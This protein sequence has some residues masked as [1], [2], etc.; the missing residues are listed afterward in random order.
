MKL[1]LKILATLLSPLFLY[2]SLDASTRLFMDDTPTISAHGGANSRVAVV[3][4]GG[5]GASPGKQFSELV[6]KLKERGHT[7]ILE[8]APREFSARKMIELTLATATPDKYD[9]ILF[10]GASKGGLLS[11]DTAREMRKRGDM[12]PV[13]IVMID[14]PLYGPDVI[15]VPFFLRWASIIPLGA[16]SNT[17]FHPPFQD[18]DISQMSPAVNQQELFALWDSYKTWKASCWGDEGRYV[19]YHNW[20]YGSVE[21]LPNTKWAFVQSMGDTF[22]DGNSALANWRASVGPVGHFMVPKAGHISFHDWPQEYAAQIGN[23]LEYVS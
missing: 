21:P 20:L 3:A 18:G 4:E 16:I 6:P 8:T 12:R 14:S 13:G 7:Y 22:V 5:A 9:K 19:F 1:A 17:W 15:G 23:G 11:Y 10:V 2:V